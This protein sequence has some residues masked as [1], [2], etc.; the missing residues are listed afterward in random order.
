MGPP[1]R[2]VEIPLHDR[3]Q[4]IRGL[5]LGRERLLIRAK[6]VKSQMALDQLR[7]EPIEGATAGRDELKNLFT[8][9]LPIQ[10]ALYG[11]HLPFDSFHA[12]EHPG[13]VLSCVRQAGSP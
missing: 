3:N 4:L 5:K 8:F 9:T 2:S 11:F 6:N 7:H 10:R 13:F 1:L 12:T